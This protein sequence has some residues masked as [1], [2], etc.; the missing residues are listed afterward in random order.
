RWSSAAVGVE[1]W[2]EACEGYIRAEEAVLG[3]AEGFFAKKREIEGRFSARRAQLAALESRGAAHDARIDELGRA[4]ENA[5]AAR[6]FVVDAASAA[7]E[8]F[9]AAVV[10]LARR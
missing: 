10:S 5:L 7:L 8:A 3:A 4:V 6:P 1:R 2:L 9:E